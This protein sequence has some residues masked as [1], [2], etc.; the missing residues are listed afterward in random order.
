MNNNFQTPL[1]AASRQAITMKKRTLASLLT[2]LSAIALLTLVA[3]LSGCGS[4]TPNYDTKFGDA[5]RQSRLDMTIN[6]QAGQDPNPV[7]GMDGVSA[8]D[9][10]AR[11]QSTFREPPPVT[12]VINIGG[13]VGG[14]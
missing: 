2:L 8:R 6:P 14:K 13:A 12:N 9:A 3:L 1:H 11:Y 4:T 10:M 7:W 5:V